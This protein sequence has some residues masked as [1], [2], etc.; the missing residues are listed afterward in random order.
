LSAPFLVGERIYLRKVVPEDATQQYLRWINDSRVTR[1][2]ESGRRPTSLDELHT[3][4]TS[5]Q[6]QPN[7]I[8]LAIIDSQTDKHIGNIKLDKINSIHQVA[9][10][11]I[12]IGEPDYWGKG[13]GSEAI[14][15]VIDY[16]FRTLNLRKITLGVLSGNRNAYKCYVKLGFEREATV[17]DQFFADGTYHDQIIMSKWNPSYSRCKRVTAIV[18]ARMGSSRLPG[19]V[20]EKIGEIP[21]ISFLL[22]RL[23]RSSYVDDVVVATSL[24]EKDNVLVD[25]LQKEG[26]TVYRGSEHDVLDRFYRASLLYPSDAYLRLTGDCP[27]LDPEIVDKLIVL[28]RKENVSYASNVDPASYP[29]GVDVEIFSK[30]ALEEAWFEAKAPSE[31]EHVTP[32]IRNHPERF[33]KANLS[34]NEDLSHLRWTLDT[35]EDLRFLR[36]LY[37]LCAD[38]GK[39]LLHLSMQEILAMIEKK[40]EIQ[41]INQHLLRNES[42]LKQI[43]EEMKNNL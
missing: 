23:N 14:Q 6:S 9:E 40:P 7:L 20:L 17:R 27:L 33:P 15:L 35:E 13:Y 31:R 12:M 39:N 22:E 43:K 1:Y 38:Y 25:Y 4:I 28:F 3:F 10:L 26:I 24:H 36:E 42:Y 19:K 37:A 2:L 18:Q 21:A 5:T 16:A 30:R 34:N 29:D 41:G 11:G 32:F 8:F